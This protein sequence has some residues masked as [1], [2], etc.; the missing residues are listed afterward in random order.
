MFFNEGL[1]KEVNVTL[2]IKSISQ[3]GENS[4]L[5]KFIIQTQRVYR[6]QVIPRN[7]QMNK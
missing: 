5:D 2:T 7:N 6:I 4:Y 1:D 3:E